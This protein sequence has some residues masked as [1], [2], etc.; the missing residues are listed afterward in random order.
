MAWLVG[1]GATFTFL[2]SRHTLSRR[3][4][5][6][7]LWELSRLPP[8]SFLGTSRGSPS[9]FFPLIQHVQMSIL[10]GVW[11]RAGGAAGSGTASPPPTL[12]LFWARQ[13]AVESRPPVSWV[14]DSPSCVGWN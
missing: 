2:C 11:L 7:P 13:R 6:R 1:G 10:A 9:A 8:W 14:R 5:S 3:R 4:P 12:L